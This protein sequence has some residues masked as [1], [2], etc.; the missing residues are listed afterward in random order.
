MLHTGF[1]L[2]GLLAIT[3][4]YSGCA[5]TSTTTSTPTAGDPVSSMPW[6]KPASWEG[7][8]QLGGAFGR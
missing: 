6:N 2:L 7:S 5:S 3:I 1:Y 8:G 4:A